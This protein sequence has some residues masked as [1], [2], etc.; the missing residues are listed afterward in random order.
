MRFKDLLPERIV[1]PWNPVLFLSEWSL[2][3][4][5]FA[6]VGVVLYSRDQQIS[7]VRLV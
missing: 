6:R 5:P 3:G 1:E 4:Y 2:T 7:Q